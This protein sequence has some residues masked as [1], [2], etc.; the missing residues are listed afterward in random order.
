LNIAFQNLE[1]FRQIVLA[2]R[3]LFDQLR[4]R[5]DLDGFVAVVVRLGAERGCG[6]TEQEVRVALRECRR[7][8][9]ERWI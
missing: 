4:Q 2:D 9:L 1:R 6:F 7:V 8:W 5:A 3:G